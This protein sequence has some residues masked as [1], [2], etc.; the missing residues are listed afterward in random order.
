MNASFVGLFDP[1]DGSLPPEVEEGNVEYKLKLITPSCSRFEHLVTQMKW[2]LIEG[3]GEAIY[4]I[5]VEDNGLLAGLNSEDMELSL[6]TL[7]GMADRLSATAVVRERVLDNNK[8][9]A[10]VLVRRVPE[11]QQ[12]IDL[13]VAVVGNVDAGKSTVVGVLTHGE[14][15][16][17]RG[18]ARLNLFRHLHEIQTGHTSSISHE[19]MGFDLNGSIVNYNVCR[20]AEEICEESTK[21][22]TFIDLAGHPKYLRTTVC[23]LTGYAPHFAMVLVSANAGVIGTTR[24]HL[25]LALA[26]NVPIFIVVNKI[27]ICQQTSPQVLTKTL[28]QL[29]FLLKSPGCKKVPVRIKTKD[30]VITVAGTMV[31]ERVTPIFPVSCVTGEGLDLLKYFLNV[32]PACNTNA[33]RDKLIELSP[34]FQAKGI[35]NTYIIYHSYAHDMEEHFPVVPFLLSFACTGIGIKKFINQIHIAHGIVIIQHR[36]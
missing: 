7:K 14:L 13:R 1:A 3:H 15:D 33:E 34:E 16:N 11:D 23:G 27:D 8:K 12:I 25:G 31:K 35:V 5:G 4:E 17:G 18:K 36:N 10:E 6:T 32:L 26:L 28:N 30:D 2:R 21:L 20:T 29:E 19:I 22:V 24:E 9:A